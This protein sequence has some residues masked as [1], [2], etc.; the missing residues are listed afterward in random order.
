MYYFI[1][2]SYCFVITTNVVLLAML[3]LQRA[4]K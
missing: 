2:N 4:C 3:I 1:M